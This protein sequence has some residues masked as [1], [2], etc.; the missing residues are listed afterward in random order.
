[1]AF[2]GA[3]A[4]GCDPNRSGLARRCKSAFGVS[5]AATPECSQAEP[6]RVAPTQAPAAPQGAD[7]FGD[8]KSGDQFEIPA[9]L[10][11][12]TN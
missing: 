4:F 5:G 6:Q 1:M 10:R 7:L 9:F 3:L 2:A 8:Q 12:Q 11:R